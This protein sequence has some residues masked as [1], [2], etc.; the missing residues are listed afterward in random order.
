MSLRAQTHRPLW[1]SP[2]PEASMLTNRGESQAQTA[3]TAHV[4]LSSTRGLDRSRPVPYRP[5]ASGS[6]LGS[7]R[8][9]SEKSTSR[10]SLARA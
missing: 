7:G 10:R 8:G 5:Q 1:E 3:G 6:Y 4:R 9:H 2:S